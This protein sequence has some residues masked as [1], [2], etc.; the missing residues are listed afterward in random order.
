MK[1]YVR[2]ITKSAQIYKS[3]ENLSLTS[4]SI[5]I[6]INTKICFVFI[7][8]WSVDG[9]DKRT[10]LYSSWT[11]V[12]ARKVIKK[13]RLNTSEEAARIIKRT[14]GNRMFLKYSSSVLFKPRF[15]REGKTRWN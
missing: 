6:I 12:Y 8:C 4:S 15:K 3:F 13:R 7:N 11:L 1:Y 14:D 5:G 9:R 2:A 10:K